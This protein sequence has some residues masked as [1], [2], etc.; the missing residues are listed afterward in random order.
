MAKKKDIAFSVQSLDNI[1]KKKLDEIVD[2]VLRS[3]RGAAA[4]KTM[5]KSVMR[6]A[7][8]STIKSVRKSPIKAAR[9]K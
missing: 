1:S 8:K 2:Q 6:S 4:M 7:L 5:V 9:P 3:S